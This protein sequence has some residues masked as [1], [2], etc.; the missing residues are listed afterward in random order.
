MIGMS[1]A[2]FAALVNV[3]VVTARL[4]AQLGKINATMVGGKWRVT[5]DEYER[6]LREGHLVPFKDRPPYKGS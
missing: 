3:T 2:Q 5:H 4:W 6:Y 1:L